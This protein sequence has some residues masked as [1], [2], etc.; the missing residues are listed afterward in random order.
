MRQPLADLRRPEWRVLST[1]VRPPD[2]PRRVTRA[3]RILLGPARSPEAP[4][5]TDG[6]SDYACSTQADSRTA[7]PMEA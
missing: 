6:R 2:G 1:S 4:P 7:R 5:P 3:F